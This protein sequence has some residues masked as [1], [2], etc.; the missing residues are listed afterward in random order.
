VL[1]SPEVVDAARRLATLSHGLQGSKDSK[2][3]LTTGLVV[4][5]KAK[6]HKT[7]VAMSKQI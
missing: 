5:M 4:G 2:T 7:I 3:T 6:T 1:Q